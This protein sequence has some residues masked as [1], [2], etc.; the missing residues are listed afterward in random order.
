MKKIINNLKS[1]KL[2]SYNLKKVS[3]L[4]MLK[5]TII[6][7][8]LL[9]NSSFSFAATC[10]ESDLQTYKYQ[11]EIEPRLALIVKSTQRVY[12]YSAPKEICKMNDQFMIQ[13]DQVIAYSNY[14]DKAQQE[15]MYV[16][17]ANKNHDADE[18]DDLVEGWIKLKDFD[19][20]MVL[21][22]E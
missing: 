19:Q 20:N 22:S 1:L 8:L 7:F 10:F 12:F 11:H 13:N 6:M 5:K 18:E 15:W 21:S 14:K 2:T 16:M 17:Y 4:Y 9:I 3:R